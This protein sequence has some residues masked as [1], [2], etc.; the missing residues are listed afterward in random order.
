MELH[1]IRKQW[2]RSLLDFLVQREPERL[3]KRYGIRREAD[4]D[5][6]EAVAVK[7][8]MLLKGGIADLERAAA[9]VLKE[10]RNG[11]LGRI[12]LEH[13][14]DLEEQADEGEEAP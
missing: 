13:P 5:L 14:T 8:G 3:E 7:R 12:S 2:A 10:F 11:T 1:L 4:A 6:L 9:T